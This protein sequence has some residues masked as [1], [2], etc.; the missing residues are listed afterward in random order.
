MTRFGITDQDRITEFEMKLMNIDDE[1]YGSPEEKYSCRIE[2]PSTQFARIIRDLA[3]I[4][5]TC[6]DIFSQL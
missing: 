3:N 2:M 5:E 1:N 4:G 6:K